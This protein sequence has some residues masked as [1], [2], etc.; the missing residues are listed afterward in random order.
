MLRARDTPKC[1]WRINE[2][3]LCKHINNI[4]H[5]CSSSPVRPSRSV[6]FNNCITHTHSASVGGHWAC[7][8]CVRHPLNGRPARVQPNTSPAR[9]LMDAVRMCARIASSQLTKY[10]AERA[11]TC[12]VRTHHTNTHTTNSQSPAIASRVC[13]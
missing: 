2:L 7:A 5:E 8:M 1:L 13:R 12:A 10:N 9:L 6:L 4:T 11:R 3:S